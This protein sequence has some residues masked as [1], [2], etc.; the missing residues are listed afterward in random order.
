MRDE[1]YLDYHIYMK[2]SLLIFFQI[3]VVHKISH[4]ILLEYSQIRRYLENFVW[5]FQNRNVSL[6]YL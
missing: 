4:D 5:K 3:L 1:S 6:G 2:L